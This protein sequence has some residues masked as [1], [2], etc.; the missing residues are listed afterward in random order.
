MTPTSSKKSDFCGSVTSSRSSRSNIAA[1]PIHAATSNATKK[2]STGARSCHGW[3]VVYEH[4]SHAACERTWAAR[5]LHLGRLRHRVREGRADGD[6]RAQPSH[7]A[8]GA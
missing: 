1:G 5:V 8:E 7:H 4:R 2:P 3:I 6:Q